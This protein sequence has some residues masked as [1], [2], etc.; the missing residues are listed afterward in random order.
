M[1]HRILRHV[2]H[3]QKI[4]TMQ[5]HQ[6]EGWL[7]QWKK[8]HIYKQIMARSRSDTS[9]EVVPPMLGAS[10]V[11]GEEQVDGGSGPLVLVVYGPSDDAWQQLMAK[12]IGQGIEQA[13]ADGS[14]AVTYRIQ[15]ID[16]TTFAQVLQADGIILG[17]SVENANVH[18]KVQ[19]WI[20]TQWD[21]EGDLTQKVGSAFVTAG[22][23]SAGQESSLLSLLRSMLIFNMIV[24]GGDTWT[25]PFGASAITYEGRPYGK[26]AQGSSKPP[27]IDSLFLDK[28][29]GLGE[30]V[31][32]VVARLTRE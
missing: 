4:S 2:K 1:E 5:H 14:S 21:I 26:A 13:A 15:S 6:Q 12:T 25:E 28:A 29:R 16:N 22:G 19:E 11:A 30:R 3:D 27:L 9:N 10:R 8:T 18:H 7:E 23:I 17:A 20:N 24:V 32:K 31:A